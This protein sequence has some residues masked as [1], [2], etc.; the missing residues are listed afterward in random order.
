MTRSNPNS[1]THFSGLQPVPPDPILGLTEDFKRE[2]RPNKVNLGV[3]IYQD[4]QGKSPILPTVKEAERRIIDTES[5]KAYVG[6][7]G[8][9]EY[10][11][12]LCRI[13]LGAKT[14]S[15]L[16]DRLVTIQ[17]LG[18][19]GALRVG[20]ELLK[21][22]GCIDKIFLSNPS[23]ENHS[24]IFSKV[25]LAVDSYPYFK[26]AT[27]GLEWEGMIDALGK[28]NPKDAVLLHACCH[29]PTGVDLSNEQWR[30]TA[31]TLA[32][33]G[34]AV[35]IDTAYQGF[36]TDIDSDAYGIRTCIDAGLP[37]LFAYSCSKNFGLYRER[38]GM[39]VYVAPS[40]D[41]AKL[42]RS[43]LKKLVR[44]NYSSPPSFGA[45]IVKTI[46]NDPT[47]AARWRDEVVE[48]RERIKAMRSG[49]VNALAKEG[50]DFQFLLNQHGMFSYTGLAPE[51][52]DTLRENHAVYMVR[53]G[54]MCVA[55]LNEGNLGT[56]VQAIAGARG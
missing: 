2:P 45:M 3:G 26:P 22:S 17:T 43:N 35:F 12:A 15:D 30:E 36:G 10:C 38:V 28:L 1:T 8:D 7:D 5:T 23:W 9:Q 54:R 41:E 24:A 48:M 18:G 29:N 13:V 50:I 53:S 32:R 34:T 14:L 27:R 31:A 16:R 6:I 55:A 44:T 21:L 39:L 49:L 4:A 40:A 51:V 33:R 52:V 37:L 20:G 42:V 47:L 11:E 25:G 46:L 19:S 56:V